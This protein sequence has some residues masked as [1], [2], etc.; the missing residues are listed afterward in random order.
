[1]I[2][3]D[4]YARIRRGHSFCPILEGSVARTGAEDHRFSLAPKS[5]HLL[6]LECGLP[7]AKP[8]RSAPARAM[9]RTAV[10]FARVA[11]GARI[12]HRA[13]P[14]LF[15]AVIPNPFASGKR[16]EGS[17]F[18]FVGAAV[19]PVAAGLPRQPL[20]LPM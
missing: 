16:C 7:S 10:A 8:G 4:L 14:F 18:A 6:F 11:A 13:R 1:M 17:A 15:Y 20:P 9:P 2:C 19:A 12:P 5:L 3:K